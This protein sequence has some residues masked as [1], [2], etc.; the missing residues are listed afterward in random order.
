MSGLNVM[1]GS[2]NNLPDILVEWGVAL[3]TVMIMPRILRL[4]ATFIVSSLTAHCLRAS[5]EPQI[6]KSA[7]PGSVV[8]RSEVT[9]LNGDFLNSS[10]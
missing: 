6:Q 3:G 1:L 8:W 9:A 4:S 10:L 5:G 2:N 7:N